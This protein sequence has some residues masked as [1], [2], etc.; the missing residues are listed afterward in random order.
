LRGRGKNNRAHGQQEIN[1]PFHN[2]KPAGVTPALRFRFVQMFARRQV[3]ELFKML[4]SERLGNDVFA[5]EPFAEVNQPAPMRAKRAVFSGKPVAGFFAC[6]TNS[7]V[8][9]ISFR[10]QSF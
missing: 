4:R 5:S 6:G 2:F 9:L 3:G 10:W 8:A 7:P 1:H